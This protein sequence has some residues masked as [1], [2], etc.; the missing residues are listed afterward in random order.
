MKSMQHLNVQ[1]LEKIKYFSLCGIE[2]RPNESTV[3]RVS[4]G[5][6]A[7][8]GWHHA[9][10]VGIALH[11]LTLITYFCLFLFVDKVNM[12]ISKRYSKC[13]LS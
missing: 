10:D 9:V 5:S 11:V 12:S 6:L 13:N 3:W 2:M 7:S 1:L 4:Y 8:F